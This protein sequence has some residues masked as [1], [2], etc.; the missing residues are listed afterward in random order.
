[1]DTCIGY[2]V[3]EHRTSLPVGGD[4]LCP[5]CHAELAIDT[6]PK[7]TILY[8]VKITDV[9]RRDVIV[10]RDGE[11]LS[12]VKPYS[13]SEL[14]PMGEYGWITLREQDGSGYEWEADAYEHATYT[15][16]RTGV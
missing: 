1:M 5:D 8:D 10:W 7:M 11:A 4:V 6:R 2:K 3:P 13:T 16:I 9:Q 12:V 15:V 14:N